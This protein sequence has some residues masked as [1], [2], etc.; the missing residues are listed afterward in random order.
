MTTKT[1]VAA[2]VPT[3]NAKAVVSARG[4]DISGLMGLLG[5]HAIEMMAL[6]K[7]IIALHPTG[8]ADA[9]NLAALQ[10]VLAELM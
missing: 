10:A 2:I 5:Q 1:E 6:T 7:Q 4:A 9:A 3:A 8:G